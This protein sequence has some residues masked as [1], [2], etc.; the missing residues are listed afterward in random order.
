MKTKHITILSIAACALIVPLM[1]YMTLASSKNQAPDG[2]SKLR[3]DEAKN[4][5]ADTAKP[6]PLVTSLAVTNVRVR[7]TVPGARVSAAYM[8]IASPQALTLVKAD[9]KIAGIT[10]IHSMAMRDGIMEMRALEQ[11]D[12]PANTA[13][14]LEHGGLHMMLQL[15][16]QINA[17]DKVPLT[18]TFKGA[19]GKPFNVDVLAIADGLE[20]N[21]A[22]SAAEHKH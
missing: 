7:A 15:N 17:G 21:T 2:S 14:K 19:D 13:V 5:Q 20:K 8:D 10:E 18:L 1:I 4:M 12:I 6:L 9:A 16:A 3:I 11:L 22:A